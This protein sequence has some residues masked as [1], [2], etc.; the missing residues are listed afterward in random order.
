MNSGNA[1]NDCE[2]CGME[3]V[4]SRLCS[5][6]EIAERLSNAHALE[7]KA[8]E[9]R[10]AELKRSL[11]KARAEVEEWKA[12]SKHAFDSEQELGKHLADTLDER[13]SARETLRKV[14]TAAERLD[15][16][17][18][19]AVTADCEEARVYLNGIVEKLREALSEAK[20]ES[21]HG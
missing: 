5:A 11:A 15:N 8:A 9:D 19:T 4:P 14:V 16:F 3:R 6:C 18:W 13:D 10:I 12:S 7:L 20:G 2:G 21:Q 1:Y 17:A